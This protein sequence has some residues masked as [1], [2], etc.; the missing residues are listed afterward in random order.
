MV[1]NWI[2]LKMPL[3]Y[4]FRFE[5]HV[6]EDEVQFE[7]MGQSTTLGVFIEVQSLRN[8]F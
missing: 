2:S 3:Q 8:N 6:E 5:Q 7:N 4:K 1:L